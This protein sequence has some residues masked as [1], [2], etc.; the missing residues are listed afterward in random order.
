MSAANDVLAGDEVLVAVTDAMVEFHHRYYP[1]QPVTGKA[2]LLSEKLVV[3]VLGSVGSVVEQ[4]L[5]ELQGKPILQETRSPF[6]DAMQHEFIAAVERLSGR[7]VQAFISNSH[8]DPD[9]ELELFV[10]SAPQGIASGRSRPLESS[11]RA[12]AWESGMS[13]ESRGASPGSG[14][15]YAY[16][17]ESPRED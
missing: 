7:D 1:G 10:L 17:W 4:A 5:I 16:A 2:R 6:Q 13:T 8:V 14:S 12:Y 9:I 11:T 15:G 3:C